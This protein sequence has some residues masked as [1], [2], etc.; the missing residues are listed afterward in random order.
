MPEIDQNTIDTIEREVRTVANSAKKLNDDVQRE[1]GEFRQLLNTTKD[2]SE[3]VVKDRIEKFA[4]SIETKTQA[5]E[6]GFKDVSAK[7]EKVDSILQ[8]PNAAFSDE[9]A[10]KELEGIFAFH[11][12]K[13]AKSGQLTISADLAPSAQEQ[14]EIRAW[15]K[16]FG[17]YLRRDER[18][19][20]QAA[21]STGSDPDGGFIV[22]YETSSRIITRVFETSPLRQFADVISISTKELLLPRDEGEMGS[23]WVGETE[24]RPETSAGQL[25]ASKIPVHEM[26]AAPRVTQSMIEDA[27]VDIESWVANKL[28][29]RFARTETSAFFAGN[30]VNRPRGI[31]TYPTAA[32]GST[33]QN[34]GTIQRVVSGNANTLTG[35]GIIDL[36]FSLKDYYTAN[37]RFMANRQSVRDAM[38]LKDGQGNYLWAS[39]DIRNDVPS[40]IL[41]YPV[42][43]AADMPTVASGALALAFGDFRAAYT[44]VDRL[45]ISLLRDPYLAKPY[46][47]YYTRKRVG[48]DVVDFDAIKLQVIST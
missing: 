29:D 27:G 46:V 6:T 38:K 18:G 37:A 22:P 24:A 12:E 36:V 42:V 39:G 20:P 34:P 2:Q 44:I 28:A 17:A 35:D 10:G 31:L 33:G 3:A 23:G 40:T 32:P 4:A 5:L 14:D 16:A 9:E 11:K 45:G 43:R 13:L 25:G 7:L 19:V 41:G 26:Y 30:G 48:G 21:L 8:R 1:L 15:N 47:I